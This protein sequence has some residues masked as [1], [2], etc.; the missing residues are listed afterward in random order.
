MVSFMFRRLSG[1]GM[2]FQAVFSNPDSEKSSAV[3]VA[4]RGFLGGVS[5]IKS[6]L[7]AECGSCARSNTK[8][9]P[10]CPFRTIM[11][12]LFNKEFSTMLVA[13]EASLKS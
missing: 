6:S 11:V 4:G 9:V 13:I 7:G 5:R 10:E 1:V 2:P 8:V 3:I 12:T